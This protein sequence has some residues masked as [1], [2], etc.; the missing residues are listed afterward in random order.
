MKI[1]E[2]RRSVK[3]IN[4]VRCRVIDVFVMDNRDDFDVWRWDS[5]TIEEVPHVPVVPASGLP[6]LQHRS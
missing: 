1:F 2:K 4:G 5:A 6:T 3:V